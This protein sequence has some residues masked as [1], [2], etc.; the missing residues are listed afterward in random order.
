MGQEQQQSTQ[1]AQDIHE[2][3][4]HAFFFLFCLVAIVGVAAVLLGTN[5]DNVLTGAVST[6]STYSSCVDYGN[7]TILSNEAGSKRV[8]KDICT[9]MKNKFLRK[10]ACVLSNDPADPDYGEYTFTYTKIALC[11]S[12]ASC[13][14]DENKAAYCPG[15]KS[16]EPTVA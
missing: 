16:V 15:D 13:T 8:K 6:T 12:G 3:H 9:G 1:N 10:A 11:D 7:Y 5:S 2:H 4:S 14:R